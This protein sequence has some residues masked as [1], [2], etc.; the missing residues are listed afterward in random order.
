MKNQ[1]NKPITNLLLIKV[2]KDK[3]KTKNKDLVN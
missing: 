1:G 3:T 2:M